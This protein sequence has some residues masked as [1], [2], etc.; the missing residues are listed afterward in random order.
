M[1]RAIRADLTYEIRPHGPAQNPAVTL[2]RG[3]AAAATSR[4]Y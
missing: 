2:E 1:T 3:L 4:C